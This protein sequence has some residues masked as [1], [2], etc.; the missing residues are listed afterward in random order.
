M[1]HLGENGIVWIFIGISVAVFLIP[2]FQD[3]GVFTGSLLRQGQFWRLITYQFVHAGILHLAMNMLGLYLIGRTVVSRLGATQFALIYFIGGICGALLQYGA[4]SA[5]GQPTAIVGASASLSALAF[6]FATI[7][8]DMRMMVFPIPVP[9][10]LSRL[11]WGYIIL[12]GLLGLAALRSSSV[13]NT[14]YLAHVGGALYGVIHGRYFRQRILLPV[15]RFT[16]SAPKPK[17]PPVYRARPEQPNVIDA[18]FT[19]SA[20]R[21]ADY[22]EVLDKINREGIG[23]LTPA[24]RRILERASENLGRRND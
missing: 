21:A 24:E 16:R 22:N 4:H 14:A 8:P 23:S 9:I 10:K 1:P 19:S 17:R 2:P 6:V 7:E 15:I 5:A 20:K 11:A 12:N 13:G 3:A 18:E